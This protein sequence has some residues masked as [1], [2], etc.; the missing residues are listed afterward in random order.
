MAK[1]WYRVEVSA[2]SETYFYFGSSEMSEA[3]L[4]ESLTGTS[5]LLLDDLTYFDEDRE[6]RTWTEWDPHYMP[7]IYLNPTRIVS[8][9]RLPP[10]VN[11]AVSAGFTAI[12][13]PALT[14]A[15]SW[16]EPGLSTS[17]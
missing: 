8:V 15:V 5:F 9:M 1:F 3:K 16:S 14:D 12:S 6:A 7:R 17:V 11:D 13:R 4:A 10:K 2:A